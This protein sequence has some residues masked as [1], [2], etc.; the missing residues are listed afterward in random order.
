MADASGIQ[1]AKGAITLR[2]TLLWIEGMI[3]GATQRSIGL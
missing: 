3:S 2:S 1:D